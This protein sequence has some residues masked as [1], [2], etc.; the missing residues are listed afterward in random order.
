MRQTFRALRHR[1]FRLF[2]SGQIVSLIGTWMQSVA[3]S[4]LV[5]RLTHSELLLGT[6]WFCSQ[7]PVFVL[8]PLGG[9]TADRES[10]HRIV[11]WTQTLLMLQAFALAVLTLTGRVQIWHVFALSLFLGAVNAFDIPA[12][13]S[14]LVELTSPEDLMNAISLNSTTFNAA[15]VIG[16]GLAGILVAA[17]GEGICFLINGIS[18]IAVIACLLAMKLQP[19]DPVI[20][21]DSP[22]AHLIDGFRY[23][24]RHLPVRTLLAMMSAMTVFGMP[25]LVLL[26]IFADKVFGQGSRGL[27]ALSAVM[28]IGAMGGALVVAARSSATGLE[29]GIVSSAATLGAAFVAFAVSPDFPLSLVLMAVIG[30]AL[31]RQLACANSLIQTLIPDAYRGRTMALYSMAV[32]GLGPFGS[33]AAGAAAEHYGA[34]PTVLVSGVLC[35]ACALWFRTQVKLYG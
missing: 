5:Y 32:V 22:F 14:L 7:I 25:V 28:G 8:A 33:L 10:R 6:A 2:L 26:P 21:E 18:F 13:Q 11:V 31:F 9:L 30:F 16:P 20:T 27:G 29:K 3:Q 17:V 24:W 1:N 15:R 23:A 4:W 35:L 19:R 12:R 34:R